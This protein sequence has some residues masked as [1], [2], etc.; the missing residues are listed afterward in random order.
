MDEKTVQFLQLFPTTLLR[1]RLPD[2][3]RL[4]TD[5]LE[6]IDRLR[7]AAPKG[8]TR[9]N[10]LGWQSGNLD[11]DVPAV[12]TFATLVL[13]RA[14]EFGLAHNWSFP[15]HMQLIMREIWANANGK[16]A[17]NNIHNHPNSLLSGVY[18]VKAEDDYGDLLFFDPRKQASVTQPDFSER[19][20]INSSIHSIS[21]EVGTLIIFPSWLEHSVNQNLSDSDRISRSFN[22]NLEHEQMLGSEG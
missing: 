12:A 13:E 8:R 22:I 17:Y 20:Q 15:S 16:H 19:T 2:F 11:F 1:C 9:S 5:L 21:P 6:Y 7:R 18:Y 10:A 14:R 3:E 4:N